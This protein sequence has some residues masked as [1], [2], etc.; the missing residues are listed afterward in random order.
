M[1]GGIR[2]EGA[3]VDAKAALVW[4]GSKAGIETRHS[5]A[6]GVKGLFI[7]ASTGR[8]I[9]SKWK[10]PAVISLPAVASDKFNP[11]NQ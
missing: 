9:F 8:F 7:L 3:K 2:W 11:P 5:K 4:S 6:S 1:L 10:S